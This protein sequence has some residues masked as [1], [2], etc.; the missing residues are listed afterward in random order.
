MKFDTV[1]TG[2]FHEN[3]IW[4]NL[5]VAIAVTVI[6]K[7]KQVFLKFYIL[8]Q[9]ASESIALS[10]QIRIDLPVFRFSIYSC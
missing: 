8:K 5:F 7:N 3:F 6:S 1:S 4:K 2:Y 9:F 10:R